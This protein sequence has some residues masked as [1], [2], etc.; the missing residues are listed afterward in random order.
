MKLRW[1]GLLT[2]TLATTAV[3]QASTNA[4]AT[5]QLPY[6]GAS[7]AMSVIRV[8]GALALVF[9]VFVGGL[10]LFRNWT[11]LSSSRGRGSKLAVVEAKGLGHRQT[12][13]V[14]GYG[15]ERMLVAASP[16][17]VSLLTALPPADTEEQTVALKEPDP[18]RNLD[19]CTLLAQ[20]V[21]R[22]P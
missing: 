7:A 22:R 8:L 17:G 10:W 14:V 11:N 6:T 2:L 19:F 3:C 21:G 18:S 5:P 15:R 13:F 1:P 12:L 9:S 20:V 16:G 4:L